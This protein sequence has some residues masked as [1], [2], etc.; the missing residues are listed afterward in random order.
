MPTKHRSRTDILA[1]ILQS[2]NGHPVT[3]TRLL[4]DAYLS[5]EQLK[6][7]LHFVIK[8]GLL[9]LQKGTATYRTTAKGMMFLELYEEMDEIVPAIRLPE[10]IL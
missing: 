10:V 8:N 5:S 1:R 3:K 4:Y 6:D 2:A 9:E 7:Y